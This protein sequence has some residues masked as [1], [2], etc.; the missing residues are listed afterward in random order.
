M[1]RTRGP[2]FLRFCIPIVDVLNELGGSG[3]AAEITDAVIE[4]LQ[5]SE[6]EQAELLKNG[7][8]R[9]RNQIAWARFYLAKADLIDSSRYGVWAHT[10]KGRLRKFTASEIYDLFRFVSFTVLF[11]CKKYSGT[12]S[13]SQVRDF[14]GAMQGR[15]DKGII[16]TT[17]T[18]TTDAKR[19]A[20]RDGAPPIELVVSAELLSQG[21]FL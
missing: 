10:D 19:E 5:I 9:V 7:N 4:R 21:I 20:R 14:R 13:A 16:M 3:K 1:E 11:Q 8:S 17:G 12:V 18:F 2:W 6:E 15:A